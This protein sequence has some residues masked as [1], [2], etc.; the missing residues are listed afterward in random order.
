MLSDEERKDLLALARRSVETSFGGAGL[1]KPERMTPALETKTG[2]FVTLHKGGRLRGC[3]GTFDRSHP[4]WHVIAEYARHAAFQDTRFKPA[5]QGEIPE[6]EFEISVL[7]PLK[8]ID[9][10]LDIRLGTD[11]IWLVGSRG[12]RGTFLPQVATETGWTKEEFLSNCAS[13]KAGM[14]PDAWRDPDLC[15]VYTYTAEVFSEGED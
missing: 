13:H 1:P 3:I 8:K 4:L 14:A 11:G 12:E 15:T 5:T 6:I 9:N 7:S 2:G 10:P